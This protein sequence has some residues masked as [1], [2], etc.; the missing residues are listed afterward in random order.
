MAPATPPSVS[1]GPSWKSV[2]RFGKDSRPKYGVGIENT[3][4]PSVHINGADFDDQD[5]ED[6]SPGAYANGINL[7]IHYSSQ[8]A[9]PYYSL[10]PSTYPSELSSSAGEENYYENSSPS[11]SSDST[12]PPRGSVR[13]DTP[14]S[15]RSPAISNPPSRAQSRSASLQTPT[16]TL[17]TSSRSLSQRFLGRSPSK[18]VF[19]L[20]TADTPQSP[21]F[22]QNPASESP[23]S[24]SPPVTA[25]SSKRQ[26][27]TSMRS[28]QNIPK[29]ESVKRPNAARRF[30]RRVASAPNAKNLFSVP[31][32][33]QSRTP[34]TKNGLLAP[35]ELLV[36]PPLP[37]TTVDSSKKK[38][39]DS[40]DTTSSSSSRGASKYGL[41][42]ARGSRAN[43][44]ASG[45]IGMS[46]GVDEA[47][48]RFRR[49]YSSNSIKVKAVC[50]YA[51]FDVYER[52]IN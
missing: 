48:A 15:P 50:C 45:S 24:M 32:S 22:P 23:R 21:F 4:A 9:A 29:T 42:S 31:G 14:M 30:I 38:N 7:N 18:R 19:N 37:R 51:S 41:R 39:G 43:S 28:Q 44:V 11:H 13:L 26:T 5:G 33:R 52:R 36:P 2:F 46:P 34:T 17:K 1:K 16:L 47:R 20:N 10:S 25:D 8:N 12:S 49:T 3:P 6:H 40:L 27:R 35:A